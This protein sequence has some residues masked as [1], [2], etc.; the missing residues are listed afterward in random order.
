MRDKY[1]NVPCYLAGVADASHEHTAASLVPHRIDSAMPAPQSVWPAPAS[2][3]L[4]RFALHT[5]DV[6]H[7]PM[8]LPEVLQLPE[9]LVE[10]GSRL[11][12]DSCPVCLETYRAGDKVGL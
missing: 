2:G 11:E 7:R 9:V 12:G 1:A 3:L 6:T 5:C 4:Y 10:A 8:A